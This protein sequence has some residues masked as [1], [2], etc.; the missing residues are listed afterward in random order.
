MTLHHLQTSTELEEFLNKDTFILL[1]HS[2]TCPISSAAY[3]EFKTFAESN[4]LIPA[5]YLIVQEDSSLS[6]EI[7]ETFH[8]KHESPQVI[9]FKNGNVAFHASHWK[10]TVGLLTEAINEQ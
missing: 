8:V 10:I 2:T 9:L 4:P 5:A 6:T 3:E 7:V 1:K